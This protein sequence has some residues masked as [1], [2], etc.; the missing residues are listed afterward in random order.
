M[1]QAR[2]KISDRN[3]VSMYGWYLQEVDPNGVLQEKV[4]NNRN[5]VSM[6]GL[7]LQKV[8]LNVDV[9]LLHTVVQVVE[10]NHVHLNIVDVVD[11]V[12]AV[13]DNCHLDVVEKE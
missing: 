8:D 10:V 7:Y 6:Y 3:V 4:E 5:V 9:N 1:K 13:V 12:N 11:V 2:E